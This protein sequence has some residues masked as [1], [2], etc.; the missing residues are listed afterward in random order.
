MLARLLRYAFEHLKEFLAAPGFVVKRDEQAVGRPIGRTA[1]R[2]RCSG[3]IERRAQTIASSADLFR[4]YTGLLRA[5][6]EC[7]NLR[8]EMLAQPTR[9]RMM[10]GTANLRH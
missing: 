10:H 8:C 9:V 4:Q 2:G 6:F 5:N 1:P 3:F 7:T